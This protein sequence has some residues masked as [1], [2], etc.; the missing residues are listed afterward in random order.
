MCDQCRVQ[1]ERDR[2]FWMAIRRAILM[3]AQA[4]ADRYPDT[5]DRQKAA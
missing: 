5:R 2:K 1:Q 4:I 3:I